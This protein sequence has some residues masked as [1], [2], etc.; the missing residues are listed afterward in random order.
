MRNA[1]AP[2]PV[3]VVPQ[4]FAVGA[5]AAVL[6]PVFESGGEPTRLDGWLE[7]VLEELATPQKRPFS[8][9]F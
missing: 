6:V 5:V 9:G 3:S 1:P 4:E 7:A 2:Q 8:G